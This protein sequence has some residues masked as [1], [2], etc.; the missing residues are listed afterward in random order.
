MHL[1]P[2][3]NDLATLHNEALEAF[4]NSRTDLETLASAYHA[5]LHGEPMKDFNADL[6]EKLDLIDGESK[7]VSKID[8]AKMP[9]NRGTKRYNEKEL[10]EMSAEQGEMLTGAQKS[11]RTKLFQR[12]GIPDPTKSATTE[13]GKK[14][15]AKDKA[16][17]SAPPTEDEAV[18]D[19]AP[20]ADVDALREK[21]GI[22]CKELVREFGL[23]EKVV[24]ELAKYGAAKMSELDESG[25]SAMI[26]YATQQLA[27]CR[28]EADE[29]EPE[30]NDTDAMFG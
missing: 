24:A 19:P 7:P 11:R 29:P 18:V 6:V 4:H 27:V 13:T 30:P 21:V 12:K 14:A 15:A 3:L 9:G 1:N 26:D 17:M 2:T 5:L 16:V 22:M 8:T 28:G 20:V 23:G 10:M 25:A